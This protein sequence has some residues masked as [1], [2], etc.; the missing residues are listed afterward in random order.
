MRRK[1]DPR[2]VKQVLEKKGMSAALAGVNRSLYGGKVTAPTPARGRRRVPTTKPSNYV[3]SHRA[4]GGR[5]QVDIAHKPR[6]R[7]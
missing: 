7:K 5:R 2:K 1:L 4:F 6:K 3:P